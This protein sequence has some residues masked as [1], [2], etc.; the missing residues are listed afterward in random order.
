MRPVPGAWSNRVFRLVVGTDAYAVKELR[1]PWGDPQNADWL[2]E[3]WAFEQLAI[4]ARV[5]APEPI[6]NP[7]DGGCIAV[8]ARDGDLGTAIVRVHRWVEGQPAPRGAVSRELARWAGETL[9]RMHR[10]DVKPRR[11][12]AFP[13]LNVDNARRWPGLVEAARQANPTWFDDMRSAAAS[14]A[15][16]AELAL[17]SGDRTHDEVMS[18]GDVDQKNILLHS[19]GPYLCDW[20]VAAPLVPSREVA[21]VAMSMA[22]W[23]RFDIAKEVVSGYRD[24]GGKLC[25][26]TSA[27]LGQPMMVSIDWLVLNV[28]RALRLRAVTDEEAALGGR[29]VPELLRQLPRQVDIALRVEQLLQV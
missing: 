11:R 28:E 23:K 22:V 25:R 21:D 4:A 17:A 12:D 3:A 7:D 13:T 14:V 20:D 5:A 8:V 1:N 15:T 18:H 24:A 19:S 6:V 27:D 10:L 2:D 29:L 9:A 16:I 26:V